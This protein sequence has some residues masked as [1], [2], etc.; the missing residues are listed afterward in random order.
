MIVCFSQIKQPQPNPV[1]IVWSI[2]QVV[3]T[4]TWMS[5]T[6]I[7]FK[8]KW[9]ITTLIRKPPGFVN[10]FKYVVNNISSTENDFYTLTRNYGLLLEISFIKWKG[11]RRRSSCV[12]IKILMDHLGVNEKHGENANDTHCFEQ[13]LE[14]ST[15]QNSHWTTTYLPSHRRRK[16]NKS[17]WTLLEK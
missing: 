6:N 17:C 10:Q 5:K 9:V 2:Q 4:S 12:G 15:P 11:F 13:I 3:L 14:V 16:T 7:R 1:D 8:Q